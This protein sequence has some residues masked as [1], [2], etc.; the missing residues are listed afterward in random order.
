MEG[1]KVN[2]ARELVERLAEATTAEMKLQLLQ[3]FLLKRLEVSAS[4]PIYDY[5]INR[6]H[7]SRGLITV[8]SLEKET[9]YSARWLQLKF[10]ERL[11][12][13]PKNFAGSIRVK[14]F[15]QSYSNGAS[16]HDL[17]WYI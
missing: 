4:D 10:V 7:Y 12:T 5:C 13:S 15:Y 9:G 3:H 1:L 8:G 6:I 16:P 14:Q 2:P 17:G 11:G